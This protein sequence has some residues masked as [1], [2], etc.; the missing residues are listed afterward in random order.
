MLRFEGVCISRM[1]ESD[2]DLGASLWII[3]TSDINL[4]IQLY[5]E[6]T[7]RD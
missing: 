1:N 7:C 6:L 2:F 4:E 3:K 5:F